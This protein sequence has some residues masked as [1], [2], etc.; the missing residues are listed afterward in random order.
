MHIKKEKGGEKM[1]IEWISTNEENLSWVQHV[2]CSVCPAICRAE[3][4]E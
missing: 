3:R 4:M 1:E 2:C